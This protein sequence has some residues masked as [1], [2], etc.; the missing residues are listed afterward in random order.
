MIPSWRQRLSLRVNQR[1]LPIQGLNPNWNLKRDKS[2]P[3]KNQN[4]LLNPNKKLPQT[5]NSNLILRPKK[6]PNL[7]L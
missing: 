1:V 3:N 5:R 4:R 2:N 7:S 6:S